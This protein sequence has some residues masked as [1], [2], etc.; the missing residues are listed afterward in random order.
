MK[1]NK[2]STKVTIIISIVIVLLVLTI[3]ITY[4]YFAAQGQTDVQTITTAT[5]GLEFD[6]NNATILA[7]DIIPVKTNKV[8]TDTK[9]VA[10]K[11]FKLK[12]VSNAEDTYAKIELTELNIPTE[13][14][15][16][17]FK[18][19]LYQGENKIATGDFGGKTS[20]NVV[21]AT[22]Q[23]VNSTVGIDYDLYIWINETEV[24]QNE[25]QGKTFS[26]KIIAS[27]TD[28]KQNTLSS[29]LLGENN[30][31]VITS[32]PTFTTTST[33]RGL[34]VQQEDNTK[35]E[36]GFPTY[37]FRGSSTNTNEGY[38]PDYIMNNYVSFGTYQTG[39]NMGKPIIWRVVRINEDGTVRLISEN[40]INEATPYNSLNVP[41][42]INT[43]GADSEAKQKIETWYLNNIGNIQNLDSKVV[44]STFCN[45]IVSANTRARIVNSVAPSFVC[46]VTANK[47]YEKVGMLTGDEL[48][49]SGALY[50]KAV[51][52]NTT[53]I[54]NSSSF[55]TMTAY[56]NE[57]TMIFNPSS[58]GIYR[59][60][61]NSGG[62]TLRAVINLSADTIVTGGDGLNA[63]T[64]YNIQ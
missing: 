46:S 51:T 39:S 16:Y 45:D 11:N 31:N 59:T 25:M 14:A 7:S 2:L 62:N 12:K 9:N 17:D 30:S 28:I 24:A 58:L 37:Y 26:V 52:N 29:V 56:D 55:W 32:A 57:R 41:R 64:A 40:Y 5:I 63:E 27:G 22:N 13:L 1:E 61:S 36:M 48:V 15:D 43:D 20:G 4:A 49:Y 44:K 23:F 50:N 54:N 3:G 34:Y 42:Y 18:W 19:M 47:I 6:D 10:H 60:G 8:L 33:N 21:I 35:S 38:N 53:Y